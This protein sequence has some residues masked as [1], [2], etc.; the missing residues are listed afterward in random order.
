[1]GDTN[2]KRKNGNNYTREISMLTP[3]AKTAKRR[4]E[5]SS[6]ETSNRFEKLMEGDLTDFPPLSKVPNGNDEKNEKDG[7]DEKNTKK[8]S[9]TVPATKGNDVDDASELK[10]TKI[11]EAMT[12][13][14]I[15][16]Y[17]IH[18]MKN[19]EDKLKHQEEIIKEQ[20]RKFQMELK[21]REVEYTEKSERQEK[22]IEKL[23]K[24]LAEKKTFL[25]NN[26]EEKSEEE[27]EKMNVKAIENDWNQRVKTKT[28]KDQ[29]RRTHEI[30]VCFA[31]QKNG[32]C[33]KGTKCLWLA[34]HNSNSNNKEKCNAVKCENDECDLFHVAP[35][36]KVFP[37]L[38]RKFQH[39]GCKNI[40]CQFVHEKVVKNST[41]C[42]E[43]KTHGG[44]KFGILCRFTHQVEP[45]P[46]PTEEEIK[47]SKATVDIENG[48]LLKN[49]DD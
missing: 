34:Y 32:V 16:K 43:W 27:K 4:S 37:K 7:K 30:P 12:E 33:Q 2:L 20:E 44:C 49:D 28:A 22:E 9:E 47:A 15:Q 29:G 19:L 31:W 10:I 39:G 46:V 24:I 21:K 26:N 1:M 8:N 6:I 25:F 3:N 45:V 11:V 13:R 35:A 14:M 17:T 23:K 48:N 18:L 40:V 36:Q 5:N 42:G 38:C 41:P